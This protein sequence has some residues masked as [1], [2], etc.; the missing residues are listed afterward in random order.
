MSYTNDRHA[1]LSSLTRL[2]VVGELH[3]VEARLRIA[4]CD[5]AKAHDPNERERLRERVSRL[6]TAMQRIRMELAAR[7][8]QRR[9]EDDFVRIARQRLD[10]EVFE[11]IYNAAAA[12]RISAHRDRPFRQ[13]DRAFRPNVT[14]RFGAS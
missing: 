13:R 10:R 3:A 8:E 2:E 6:K 4:K 11:S 9:I 5:Y 7:A 12:V 14:A 1:P